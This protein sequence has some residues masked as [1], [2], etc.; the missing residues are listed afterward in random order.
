MTRT[1]GKDWRLLVL[2]GLLVVSL[3]AC[4]SAPEDE[5]PGRHIAAKDCGGC[6]AIGRGDRSR[7]ASAPPL[8]TLGGRYELD[9][10]GEALAE[11]ISVGHP[12][13][14]ELS[15][16]ED[17]IRQLIGYMQSIQDPRPERRP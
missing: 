4:I 7:M 5:L 17:Q 14:P 3:S 10:L 1:R 8:R 2:P 9:S 16:P 13:M 15:Y 11:G 6:H 12:A